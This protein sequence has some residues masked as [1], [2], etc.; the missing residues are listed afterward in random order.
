MYTHVTLINKINQKKCNTET[1]LCEWT[2][3]Y[4]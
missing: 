2:I 4:G 1:L 3:T